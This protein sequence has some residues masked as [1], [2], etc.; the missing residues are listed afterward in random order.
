MK[1]IVEYK[2]EIHAKLTE[3]LDKEMEKSLKIMDK[4]VVLM[5]KKITLPGGRV[6]VVGESL[7]EK[8]NQMLTYTF[9]YNIDKIGLITIEFNSL[10]DK[11]PGVKQ[12]TETA[13]K[14]KIRS[15]LKK[16]FRD[17]IIKVK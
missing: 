10:A 12:Y 4:G 1:F 11:I 5:K 16:E 3:E 8:V 14:G 15:S 9:N 7:N 2:P 17:G 13:M 6:I